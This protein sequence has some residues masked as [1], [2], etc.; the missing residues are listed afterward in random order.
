MGESARIKV[1]WTTSSSASSYEIY[2]SDNSNGP[3]VLKG[4]VSGYIGTWYDNTVDPSPFKNY[5]YQIVTTCTN[6]TTSVEN[7]TVQCQNCPTENNTNIFGLR[8]TV[9]DTVMGPEG[10]Y[11]PDV[12]VEYWDGLNEYL[13]NNYNSNK[14][15]L[16]T[17]S[18]RKLAPN[19]TSFTESRSLFCH[20][21]GKSITNLTPNT[22]NPEISYM[23]NQSA[24]ISHLPTSPTL[25]GGSSNNNLGMFL[26]KK[27]QST[28]ALA[29][30]VN[31]FKL[32]I[33]NTD[34]GA[35]SFTGYNGS[36][37]YLNGLQYDN[38]NGTTQD[39]NIG[40]VPISDSSGI[41]SG[42]YHPF[43]S[44]QIGK[45]A[46]PVGQPQTHTDFSTALDLIP[47]DST[48]NGNWYVAFL[49]TGWIGTTMSNE[50][51]KC[52]V[53]VYQIRRQT[54]YDFYNSNNILT[55]YGFDLKPS[56]YNVNWFEN[57]IL[58]TIKSSMP[59]QSD[60]LLTINEGSTYGTQ[61]LH[62][63]KFFQ[64]S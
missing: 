31:K 43:R 33:S 12:E 29:P 40:G 10:P 53:Y 38:Y 30:F 8:D 54:N 7:V 61:N 55:N 26:Q 11:A 41:P 14:T 51:E 5:Y 63:L 27:Q 15:I 34:D 1:T 47:S 52:L 49:D 13:N 36:Y 35:T 17:T 32:G 56:L 3:W 4:T 60:D 9:Y 39:Y 50:P 42:N 28:H 20:K 58:W 37:V 6:G 19:S 24:L 46:N 62:Y 18:A 57:S 64:M 21:C 22:S 25:F 45:N 44:I 2:R 59:V 48:W 16:Q 23:S